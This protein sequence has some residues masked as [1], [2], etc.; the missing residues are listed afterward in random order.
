MFGYSM[1]IIATTERL[2][3]IPKVTLCFIAVAIATCVHSLR[4]LQG[5]SSLE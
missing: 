4:S 5:N 2:C 3:D 1:R